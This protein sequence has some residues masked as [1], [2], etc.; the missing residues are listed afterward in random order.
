MQYGELAWRDV[1]V[2]GEL[3]ELGTE[4]SAENWSIEDFNDRQRSREQI[5]RARFT[6]DHA[7]VLVGQAAL[8]VVIE[9]YAGFRVALTY[10]KARNAQWPLATKTKLVFWL[11]AINAD[12]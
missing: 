4:G 1:Y 5:S 3:T 8:G 12:E 10:P 2:I 7:D 6:N 9:P 11:K